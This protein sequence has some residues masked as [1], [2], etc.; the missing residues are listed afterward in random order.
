MVISWGLTIC[1]LVDEV[2]MVT[3]RC[4]WHVG[5]MSRRVKFGMYVRDGAKRCDF[6]GLW[7][8]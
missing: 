3:G 4:A 8:W 6:E 2:S 7:R 1:E 5:G